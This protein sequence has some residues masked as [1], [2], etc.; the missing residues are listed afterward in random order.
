MKKDKESFRGLRDTLNRTNI[1]IM[2]VTDCKERQKREER[3]NK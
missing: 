1:H 3:M 2:K